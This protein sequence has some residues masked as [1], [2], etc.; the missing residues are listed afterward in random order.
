[1]P[2]VKCYAV[3]EYSS[4]SE[5]TL[6]DHFIPFGRPYLNIKFRGRMRGDKEPF[7]GEDFSDNHISGQVLESFNNI[8]SGDS[9]MCGIFFHP[10]GFYQLFGFP[11]M[12]LTQSTIKIE[13]FFGRAGEELIDR[14]IATESSRQKVNLFEELLKS[15]L[16]KKI[17]EADDVEW[18]LQLIQQNPSQQIDDVCSTLNI[19]GRHLRRKFN[20][21]VGIGPKYYLRI[22]RFHRALQLSHHYNQ[23]SLQDLSFGCGYYDQSH[24]STDFR[25]FAGKHPHDYFK[26]NNR[27]LEEVGAILK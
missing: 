23:I 16:Q 3:L 20:Q 8:H 6:A 2:Y 5:I 14:M 11:M 7:M 1:M 24:F 26:R 12:E 13:D 19:S 4:S 25:Q 27:S 17:S 10:T 21:K 18:A 9:G 22:R 15:R